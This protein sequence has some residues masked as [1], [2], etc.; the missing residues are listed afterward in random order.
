M[1]IKR[2]LKHLFAPQWII[3]RAF[4]RRTLAVIEDA[5]RASEGTHGGELRFAVEAGL[6]LLPLLRGLSARQRADAVFSSLRVWDT[7]HNSGVLIYVQLVDRRIEIV[8]DRGI[9]ARVEQQQWDAICRR[10]EAAFRERRFEHGALKAIEEIT[11][12]LARHFPPREVNPNELP[13][14]PVVL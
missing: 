2:I 13:N 8:A 9:N 11:A 4:P 6:D 14:R 10:M 3:A 5:V 7:A 12:L 1:N